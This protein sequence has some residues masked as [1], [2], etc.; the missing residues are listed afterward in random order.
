[1]L[2]E[3]RLGDTGAH[4]DLVHRRRVEPAFREHFARDVEQLLASLVGRQSH[5]ARQ[6]T[7]VAPGRGVHALDL[8]GIT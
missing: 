7:A 5:G 2:V 3:H 1:V 8:S 4:R 6:R